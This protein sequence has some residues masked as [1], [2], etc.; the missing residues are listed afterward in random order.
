MVLLHDGI[1]NKYIVY[2]YGLLD[3]SNDSPISQ[4]HVICVGV[5][6]MFLVRKFL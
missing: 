4:T 6:L 1:F 2:S 3:V 5:T